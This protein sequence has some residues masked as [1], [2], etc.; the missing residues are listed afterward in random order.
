[1]DGPERDAHGVDA[2]L[3]NHTRDCLRWRGSCFQEAVDDL[4][5][6]IECGDY[7]VRALDIIVHAPKPDAVGVRG[8]D[9]ERQA[10]GS[11][12]S[13]SLAGKFRFSPAVDGN[14]DLGGEGRLG[15]KGDG[16]GCSDQGGNVIPTGFGE[17][18]IVAMTVSS[19]I[20][21]LDFT[22][23]PTCGGSKI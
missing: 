13:R 15:V 6:E 4:V 2:R 16:G 5:T 1:M 11:R 21:R 23:Q 10:A 12:A 19:M 7:D 8:R 14:I 18:V 9:L 3:D 20:D 22:V 17:A